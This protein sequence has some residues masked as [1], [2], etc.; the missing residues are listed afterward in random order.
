MNVSLSEI[1]QS[2]IT[3][4]ENL[5]CED[6]QRAKKDQIQHP[7]NSK[8]RRSKV[9]FQIVYVDMCYNP[10]YNKIDD[11][12]DETI[13]KSLKNTKVK[14]LRRNIDKAL[15]SFNDST[16]LTITAYECPFALVF[17]DEATRWKEVVPLEDKTVLSHMK[18]FLHYRNQVMDAM[19]KL[20]SNANVYKNTNLNIPIEDIQ[21]M[22]PNKISFDVFER[23]PFKF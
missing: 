8:H 2:V 10:Y 14:I 7:N 18:A 4:L 23:F 1:S 5:H 11:E 17:V 20:Q 22:N 21:K 15:E 16:Y 9:P 13:E 3:A 12:P 19:A 6:C